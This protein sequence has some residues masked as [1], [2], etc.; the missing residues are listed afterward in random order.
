MKNPKEK[1]KQEKQEATFSWL[2]LKGQH[3][4]AVMVLPQCANRQM[5]TALTTLPIY[6]LTNNILKAADEPTVE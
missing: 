3:T 4:L 1:D 5:K 6:D 2:P